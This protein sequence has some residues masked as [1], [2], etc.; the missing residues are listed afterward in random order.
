M[1]VFKLLLYRY[2]GQNDLIVGFPIANRSW[3]EAMGLIGFFVN[4]LVAR[5]FISDELI[6]REFLFRVRDVCRAAYEHHDLPFEKLVE[7]LQPPRDLSRNPIFQAM[8]TFQNI[9]L[10]YAVPSELRSTPL[11]ID[12]GSS[13]VDLTVSLAERGVELV[14]FIEYGT[15]LFNRDRIERMVGHF[16]TLLEAVLADPGQPIATLPILTETERHQIL[17]EW[18][19]TATDYPKDKCIHHLFEEQVERTPD[20]VALEFED[21]QI[22]YKDLNRRANRLA[23]YLIGL[24]IGPEKLVGIC[25]ERSIEMVVGLLGILKACGAYVPLDPTYPDERLR[26]MLEDAQVA[27]LL[28]QQKLVEDRDWKIEDRHLLS[29]VL[30]SRLQV[31]CLDRDAPSIEQQSSENPSLTIQSRN[32]AYVIYTSG[33]TGQPKGVRSNIARSL[34]AFPRSGPR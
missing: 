5:T 18:N 14:G 24:G 26:F 34:I 30:V 8:F 25:I 9:P 6:V 22:T 19:D 7:T 11:I 20:A 15:D 32:L 17:V 4:T 16:Q 31:V 28:T 3:G 29:S 13:K 33:S 23:H 2:S 1:A 12:N 21:R 27:V 10:S